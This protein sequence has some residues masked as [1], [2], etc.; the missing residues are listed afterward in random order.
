MTEN[1]TI[2]HIESV[3]STNAV[4]KRRVAAGEV[5]GFAA[6]SAAEQTAGRGR[7]GRTWL[8]TEGAVM[9]STALPL[10]NLDP[11]RIPLV[12]LAAALAV[13]DCVRNA[14]VTASIK[15]P[16]DVVTEDENG[17]RKLSGIL[18]ELASAP[19]GALFAI[20]GIGVNVNAESIPEGLLQPASSIFIETGAKTD[21]TAFKARLAAQMRSEADALFRDGEALLER[22][23]ADCCTLGREVVAQGMSSAVFRGKAVGIDPRGRLLIEGEDRTYTVGAADVSVRFN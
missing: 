7:R 11:D 8:N 2:E 19:D 23:R 20:V 6:V 16:N 18:S 10:K 15:W 1:I 5:E 21:L 13:L 9:L 14:G 12:S 4:L 3:D 22:F 17:M